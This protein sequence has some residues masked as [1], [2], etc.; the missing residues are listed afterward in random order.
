MV[1]VALVGIGHTGFTPESHRYSF[2]ELMFEAALRAYEDAGIDPR[3]DVDSF[4]VCEEDYL[5][6]WSI[7]DEAVP[8]PLG[9]VLR[10]VSTTCADAIA[11]IA[12][13]VMQIK[14]GHFDVVAVEAHSK[15]SDILTHEGIVSFAFDPLYNRPLDGHPYFLAGLEMAAFLQDGENTEADCAEVVRKNRTNALRNENA[16]YGAEVSLE[17]VLASDYIFKPLRAGEVSPLADGAIVLL[18]A[19][20][21]RA[22]QLR[23]DPVWVRGMGWASDSPTIET[24]RLREALYARLAATQA[25]EMAGID[26]PRHQCQVAEV[27]DRFS[28][29]ELQHVEALGLSGGYRAGHLLQE[30]YFEA[31]GELPVN[32]SGGS[33]GAG[34]LLEASGLYRVMEVARQIRGEAG[35]HQVADVRLGVAQSWRGIPTT[36]GGVVVLEGTT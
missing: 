24:R 20:E 27:D 28:Y 16:S 17:E 31:D 12:N 33:L 14:T 32:P 36:S 22:R 25:Y 4:I 9:G 35:E 29:K 34:D 11:A 13:A 2:R 15:A 26:R 30:G 1:D 18:F 5:M 6:G 19:S 7:S 10:P 8:D 21:Q 23:D 3:K